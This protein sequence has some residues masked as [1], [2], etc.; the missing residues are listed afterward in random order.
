VFGTLQLGGERG[1]PCLRHLQLSRQSER[2]TGRGMVAGG[3]RLAG[4][5]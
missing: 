1:D 4:L 5:P 3:Q 2:G